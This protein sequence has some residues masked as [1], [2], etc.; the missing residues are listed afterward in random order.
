[1]SWFFRPCC[2]VY[3]SAFALYSLACCLP[4]TLCFLSNSP[5][6]WAP[7]S[8][9]VFLDPKQRTNANC[10]LLIVCCQNYDETQAHVSATLKRPSNLH[11][12]SALN[13]RA[14]VR[15]AMQL[16][17]VCTVPLNFIQTQSSQWKWQTYL[18]N[19]FS[20]HEKGK[21][22]LLPTWFSSS[23][24]P[25]PRSTRVWMEVKLVVS[26]IVTFHVAW[27]CVCAYACACMYVCVCVLPAP[28]FSTENIQKLLPLS[29][30]YKMYYIK[31]SLHVQHELC[32]TTNLSFGFFFC[33]IFFHSFFTLLKLFQIRKHGEGG[34]K[35]KKKP[36]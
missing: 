29:S 30:Q 5:L 32:A 7:K 35:E 17:C 25:D 33:L 24:L 4:S 22:E 14:G 15:P 27:M 36:I 9:T 2:E 10:S 34:T 26:V 12:S 1:M 18:G 8:F 11:W 20:Q 28:L 19:C 13:I 21:N 23:S 16:T 3:M 6:T 31:G